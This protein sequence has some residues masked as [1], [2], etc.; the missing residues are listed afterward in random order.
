MTCGC[1]E[2]SGSVFIIVRPKVLGSVLAGIQFMVQGV[3]MSTVVPGN[4]DVNVRAVVRVRSV[5]RTV[6]ER[7]VA[8][9]PGRISKGGVSEG[10]VLPELQGERTAT[11]AIAHESRS[12]QH[13]GSKAQ[14]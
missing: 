5:V 3:V 9:C 1:A 10:E 12:G 4:G 2:L 7:I 11:I 14:L 13:E 8:D 6:R